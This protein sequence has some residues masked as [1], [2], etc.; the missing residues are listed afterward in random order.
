MQKF[1][2][3][4]IP[5]TA[6]QLKFSKAELAYEKWGGPQHAKEGDWLVDNQGEVYT[7][8][9]ESFEKTYEAIGEG[10]FI[11]FA[12]IWAEQATSA[13]SIVTKEG[14]SFYSAGD[15][16]IY[17]NEDGTDGYCITADLF[18]ELYYPA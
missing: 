14:E 16:I 7:I 10:R 3:K 4:A 6:V 13:N 1:F 12:P 17:N 2:K 15:Y 8:E 5:I 9:A 18:K 11:K